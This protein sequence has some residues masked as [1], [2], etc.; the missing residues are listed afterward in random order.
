MS[1]YRVAAPTMARAGVEAD[2]AKVGKLNAGE[3]IRALDTQPNAAGATRVQFVHPQKRARGWVSVVAGNGGTILEPMS[4]LDLG[5]KRL[6]VESVQEPPPDAFQACNWASG[7]FAERWG[8]FTRTVGRADSGEQSL[9][10]LAS[11]LQKRAAME[12]QC[13]T[14]LRGCLGDSVVANTLSAAKGSALGWLSGATG[15]AVAG[16]GAAAAAADALPAESA[17]AQEPFGSLRGSLLGAVA[18]DSMRRAQE[19]FVQAKYLGALA[20]QLGEFSAKHGARKADLVKAAAQRLQKLDDAFVAVKRAEAEYDRRNAQEA[21]G[22]EENAQKEQTKQDFK[23]ALEAA[24][25][26][27]TSVYDRDLPHVLADFRDME[28]KRLAV[29]ADTVARY[30]AVYKRAASGAASMQAVLESKVAA[31]DSGFDMD[32]MSGDLIVPAKGVVP[33]GYLS[34]PKQLTDR[35]AELS[36]EGDGAVAAPATRM[37]ATCGAAAVDAAS[38]PAASDGL[39]HAVAALCS[40]ISQ[41]ADATAVLAPLDSTAG[42]SAVADIYAQLSSDRSG[43]EAQIEAAPASVSLHCL[44]RVLRTLKAPLLT[45]EAYSEI[46][47]SVGGSDEEGTAPKAAATIEALP[48]G[49]QKQI[50]QMVVQT[51]TA[52]VDRARAQG[53]DMPPM[54]LAML[55]GPACLSSAA[56]GGP[57]PSTEVAAVAALIEEEASQPVPATAAVK[58]PPVQEPAP[59]PPQVPVAVAADSSEREARED[60]ERRATEAERVAAAA[61]A[62]S[63]RHAEA[64]ARAQFK[65]D[66]QTEECERLGSA[67]SAAEEAR[68]AAEAAAAATTAASG[69][70]GARAAAEIEK[71]RTEMRGE[72]AAAAAEAASA[73]DALKAQHTEELESVRAA[74]Q[75]AAAEA[76]EASGNDAETQLAARALEIDKLTS[77]VRSLETDHDAALKKEATRYAALSSEHSNATDQLAELRQAKMEAAAAAVGP[78][79]CCSAPSNR[80]LHSQCG[81]GDSQAAGAE[82]DNLKAQLERTRSEHGEAVGKLERSHSEQVS[83]IQAEHDERIA[84]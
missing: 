21:L 60:A 18:A 3:V 42:W 62:E 41:A 61:T 36:A 24:I 14:S 69:D 65:L 50:L 56:P 53:V 77:Q 10:E 35:L 17:F 45:P 74:A 5:A 39:P 72:A 84:E 28:E 33:A 47:R 49:P 29:M 13:F 6:A 57:A 25:A 67:L 75:A 76:A 15:G 82:V 16:E 48:S 83:R 73:T 9:K 71:L 11:F 19:H 78:M 66:A 23:A 34:I 26:A 32:E 2:S 52:V 27:E 68:S 79:L 80:L 54:A 31:V 55:L 40:R 1:F 37:Q 58:Q 46:I 51:C 63:G 81:V 4:G 8:K 12:E 22:G 64:L 70:E 20:Q 30:A 43:Y 7:S 38:L 59:A 44:Q